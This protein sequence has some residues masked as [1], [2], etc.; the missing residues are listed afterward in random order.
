MK[1]SYSLKFHPALSSRFVS[2]IMARPSAGRLQSCLAISA[3]LKTPLR[4]TVGDITIQLPADNMKT[5]MLD[6]KAGKTDV[7]HWLRADTR[8]DH[9]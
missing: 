3:N 5:G 2:T 4:N 6:R 9:T 7:S 8:N 1:M